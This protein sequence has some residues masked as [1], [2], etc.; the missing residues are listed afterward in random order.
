M[1]KSF[2]IPGGLPLPSSA[3]SKPLPS[4]AINLSRSVVSE[5]S[6]S[7]LLDRLLRGAGLSVR[8][9]AKRLEMNDESVRQYVRGRRNRPS[10]SW[11]I[12]FVELCGGRVILEFKQK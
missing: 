12:R 9:A 6:I 4:P 8:E 1:D 3:L 7:G 2:D 10:L 11:F 5:Q